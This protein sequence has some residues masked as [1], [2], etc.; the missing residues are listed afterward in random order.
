LVN[1]FT[2]CRIGGRI[3]SEGI[4]TPTNRDRALVLGA[5]P[6]RVGCTDGPR[7]CRRRRSPHRSWVSRR[8][9]PVVLGAVQHRRHFGDATARRYKTL[10]LNSGFVAGLGTGTGPTPTIGVRGAEIRP[11]HP[12]AGEW[13]F[14]TIGPH[15][16][17][18][19]IAKDLGDS[20]PDHNRC[21][22]HVITHEPSLVSTAT[23]SVMQ[24]PE[25]EAPRQH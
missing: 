2:K 14:T 15:N 3:L 7:P 18:A 23:R 22:S 4:E 11:G 13:I 6:E 20:G 19:L 21:F 17:A 10:S 9:R 12:L 25:A 5:T 1:E 8:D 24:Y 16:A